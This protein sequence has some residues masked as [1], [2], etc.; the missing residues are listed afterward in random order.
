MS[1]N[2]YMH[3]VQQIIRNQVKLKKPSLTKL[4][5]TH[6]ITASIAIRKIVE[7]KNIAPTLDVHQEHLEA[8]KS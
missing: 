5:L 7:L 3:G 1:Q 2:D 8:V 4:T 6:K